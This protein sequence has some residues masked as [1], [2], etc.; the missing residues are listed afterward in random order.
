[1][2]A[3]TLLHQNIKPESSSFHDNK[4]DNPGLSQELA[5]SLFMGVG[6]LI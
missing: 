3:L 2:L 5:T 4:N 1:M 6:H